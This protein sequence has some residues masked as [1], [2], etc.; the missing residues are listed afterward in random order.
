M[1]LVHIGALG[2]PH[3]T[4]CPRCKSGRAFARQVLTLTDSAVEVEPRQMVTC[5]SCGHVSM[6]RTD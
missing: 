5:Q 3:L 4:V 6:Y 1:P 2:T